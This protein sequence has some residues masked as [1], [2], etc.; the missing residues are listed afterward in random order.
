MR[1]QRHVPAAL[2]PRERPSTHCTGGWVGPR[3]GLDRC[4]KSHPHPGFDPRTVQPVASRYADWATRP[5]YQRHT[6]I[7]VQLQP[8]CSINSIQNSSF[9]FPAQGISTTHQTVMFNL[10]RA[11]LLHHWR[12]L[13]ECFSFCHLPH[14]QF[15]EQEG[16]TR[17]GVSNNIT[18]QE[19]KSKLLAFSLNFANVNFYKGKFSKYYD[20]SKPALSFRENVRH[21][22]LKKPVR[23]SRH[24]K[25]YAFLKWN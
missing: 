21:L 7:Y 3:A 22:H 14:S 18:L 10:F 19:S 12:L 23:Y 5:T 8:F 6:S 11:L 9:K 16:W 1:G 4:G 17:C 20:I 13:F 2:Y 15:Q 25:D 24:R